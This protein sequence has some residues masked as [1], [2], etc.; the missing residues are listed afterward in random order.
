MRL[1]QR[2]ANITLLWDMV[3]WG[4]GYAVARAPSVQGSPKRLVVFQIFVAHAVSSLSVQD[5]A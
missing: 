1:S 2:R 3:P 5:D 4:G